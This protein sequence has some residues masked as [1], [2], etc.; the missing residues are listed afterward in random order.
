[1]PSRNIAL[2]GHSAS[3]KSSCLLRLGADRNAAEME[4]VFGR[5]QPSLERVLDWL[6]TEHKAL[7]VVVI[8][9]HEEL[10]QDLC[11]AKMKGRSE[12]Q[13]SRIH[14]VYLFKPKARLR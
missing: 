12:G 10:L 8:H 11:R 6:A 9:P 7:S 2:I 13:F 3:G 1:M 5:R 4:A 14:F